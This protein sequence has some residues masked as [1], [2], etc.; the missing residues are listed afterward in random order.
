MSDLAGLL[1]EAFS[2]DWCAD[3]D[4]TPAARLRRV[5]AGRS[6]AQ[7]RRIG[8]ELEAV[9]ARDLCEMQMADLLAFELGCHLRAAD[10]GMTSGEWLAWVG[11][12]IV[13][14]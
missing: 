5:L 11:R 1:E 13:S 12:Q 10:E 3:P 4:S 14:P 9:L 2:A 7:C 8:A 6:E